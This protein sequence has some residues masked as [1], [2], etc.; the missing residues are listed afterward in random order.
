[1]QETTPKPPV[2]PT[3]PRAPNRRERL[4]AA[5][6]ARRQKPRGPVATNVNPF[7]F[8]RFSK[9]TNGM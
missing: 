8:E 1:M 9:S 2:D 4:A 3:P 5:S 6:R 7:T